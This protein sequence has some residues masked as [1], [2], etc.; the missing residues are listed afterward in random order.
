V[1]AERVLLALV[2]LAWAGFAAL[3]ALRP[4]PRIFPACAAPLLIHGAWLAWRAF[5]SG[6]APFANIY[7]SLVCFSFLLGLKALLLIRFGAEGRSWAY[8]VPGIVAGLA[9][10][11]F[12]AS[13]AAASALSP[14]LRSP[15]FYIHVPSIFWAY[16]SL[17]FALG[18]RLRALG[19]GGAGGKIAISET[20]QAFVFL[21][22]GI[23]TGALWAEAC[24]GA[25]WSW[26][27]K[28]SWALAT[29]ILVGLVF[30]FRGRKGSAAI[31]ALAFMSML[32]TYFGVTFLLPGLHS[33]LR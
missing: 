32:F 18:S 8:L 31:T 9:A 29:W 17:T 14:A 11:F 22:A 27:P 21:G 2:V 15:W 19:P 30:H 28:E 10:L 5:S 7:E 20:R 4:S 12:P 26:D 6:H 13:Y 25:Y 33:Y 3:K 16:V 1:I 23:V 24:W